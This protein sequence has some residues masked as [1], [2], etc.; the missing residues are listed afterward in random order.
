MRDYPCEELVYEV[1]REVTADC[2]LEFG[3]YR[4]SPE[5]SARYIPEKP[6]V[7]RVRT[8]RYAK[9]AVKGIF[10]RDES[11]QWMTDGEFVADDAEAWQVVINCLLERA[12]SELS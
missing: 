5:L 11:Q 2:F 4:Q 9:D 3:V 8:V 10:A 1:I 6:C 12:K 7:I